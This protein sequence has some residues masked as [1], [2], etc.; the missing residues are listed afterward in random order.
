MTSRTLMYP[1][2]PEVAGQPGGIDA[3]TCRRAGRHQMV[4]WAE[5]ES[6]WGT[7]CWCTSLG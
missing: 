1:A 4:E 7:T 2:W 6:S 3:E 5:S